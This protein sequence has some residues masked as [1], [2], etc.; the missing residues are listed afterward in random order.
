M[1]FGTAYIIIISV[2]A[3]LLGAW[4]LVAMWVNRNGNI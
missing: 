2:T 3:T 4:A 1:I